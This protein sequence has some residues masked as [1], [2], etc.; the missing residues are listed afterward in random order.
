MLLPALA[1]AKERARQA[2]CLSNLRQWGLGV[3]IYAS[4]SND[5]IPCD[6]FSSIVLQGGPGWCGPSFQQGVPGGASGTVAD[7]YAWFNLLPPLLAE[8]TL[9]FYNA[10]M[11]TG[12]GITGAKASQYM[13]FPGGKGPIWECPSASM[14]ENTVETVLASPGNVPAPGTA[15]SAGFFSYVMNIDLKRDPSSGG[16]NYLT[17]PQMPKL[18]SLKHPSATVFMFDQVFDPITEV[19]NDS[20]QFNSVN[21]ADRFK[22]MASRHS[23]GGIIA[24]IDGHAAYF[25][26]AYV[27]NNGN[28][29]SSLPNGEPLLP[30]IIWNAA[31]RP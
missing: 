19:V 1:K 14:T 7:P 18:G 31:A 8:K 20:P 17:Y 29:N 4:D 16:A 25:K 21:P 28:Y 5:G 30:D 13:P 12:R 22:S 27:Q 24:F 9:Q 15:G 10:A 3:Q 26:T 6:G 23:K 11:T 2:N